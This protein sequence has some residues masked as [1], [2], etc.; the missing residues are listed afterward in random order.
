MAA[1]NVNLKL[2]I[3]RNE[4]T[5]LFAEADKVFVDFL[6]SI[7]ILPVG[8]VARLLKEGGS[9]VG[10]LPSLYQ[11]IKNMSVNYIQPGKNK[12]FLLEP[13]VIMPG[14]EV[15]LLLPNVGSTFRQLY[16]CQT[17]SSSCWFYVAV[18]Y[19]T[20][21]PSCKLKMDRNVR[22]VDPP[23]EIRASSTSEEGYVKETVTYVVMDDLEVKPLS[24]TTLISLL[25]KFNVNVNEPGAIEEKVV[26][27]GMDEGLKLVEASLHSKT[28]LTDVFIPNMIIKASSEVKATYHQPMPRAGATVAAD[29]PARWI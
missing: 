5:V 4:Q 18:D 12:L 19:S 20:I 23:S 25:T 7:F 10:S 6:L 2:F 28:V 14:A 26:D 8:A 9:V 21:C 17:I 22:F 27:L 16:R 3:D 1:T 29:A 15:P 13:K 24:S 11:S